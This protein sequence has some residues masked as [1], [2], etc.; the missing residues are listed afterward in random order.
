M[1][2]KYY[3]TQ[4][5][6]RTPQKLDGTLSGTR[7]KQEQGSLQK[8]LVTLKKITHDQK[9]WKLKQQIPKVNVLCIMK[10]SE[11]SL[12]G[13]CCESQSNS[14]ASRKVNKATFLKKQK[15]NLHYKQKS[16][17]MVKL[18]Y[19]PQIKTPINE[20]RRDGKPLMMATGLLRWTAHGELHLKKSS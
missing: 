12:P 15:N 16:N 2:S 14:A 11:A 1:C 18:F 10:S 8:S 5:I 13:H 19:P 17:L 7:N 20:F 9:V 4:Y 3:F 6:T